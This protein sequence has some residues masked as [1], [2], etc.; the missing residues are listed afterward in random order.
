M[1]CAC[2]YSAGAE[3]EVTHPWLDGEQT[4]WLVVQE[5]NQVVANL[6]SLLRRNTG[7]VEDVAQLSESG[8]DSILLTSW[9]PIR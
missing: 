8:F 3:P 1:A 2:G 9:L 4:A 7:G 5:P 6:A